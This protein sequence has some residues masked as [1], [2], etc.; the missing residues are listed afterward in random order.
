MVLVCSKRFGQQFEAGGSGQF[1]RALIETEEVSGAVGNS[2]RRPEQQQCGWSLCA[3]F[4]LPLARQVDGDV[5][6]Q[7]HRLEDQ[8]VQIAVKILESVV[9]CCASRVAG[10]RISKFAQ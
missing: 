6:V 4:S 2:Q 8:L 7:V 5:V 10:G 3:N 1:A 9:D